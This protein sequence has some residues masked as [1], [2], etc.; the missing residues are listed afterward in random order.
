MAKKKTAAT[1]KKSSAAPRGAVSKKP[2]LL[3][4]GGAG[5]I[6]SHTVR[7]LVE[8]G[9][10]VVVL[11]DLA[12]G[13]RAAIV[14]REVAFVKGNVGDAKT[15]E[16]IFRKHAIEGVI[17]FAAW[18]SV[19]ESVREPAKYYANNTA[20][21]LVLLDAMKRHGAKRFIFSS[22]AATFGNPQYIPIDE[23]HPQDPINPYGMSKLMLERILGD[24]DPAWG[25]RSV[26]LRYF[27]ACGASE[28]GRIGE[29]HDPET[30]LIPLVLMAAAGRRP[31]I[32]VFGRDYPTPDGTCIR[33]YIHILDLAR[34]HVMALDYLRK[35]GAS[36]GLNLGTGKG[37]SVQEIIET[38]KRV[39]GLPIPLVE[40]DRRPGDPPELVANPALAEKTL[41][42]KAQHQDLDS[43]VGTAWAWMNGPSKGRFK[44]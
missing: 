11:D 39:T 7:M 17:H 29:D 27:N 30:H 3:V 19:P 25:L 32:T 2:A 44:K 10:R 34:A 24:F 36:I 15:V 14:D 33:D 26:K 41:G 43:I 13:H 20:A 5:Y 28:D 37:H 16:G 22:T 8:A 23:K 18:T 21:P 1:K 9:E 40:G 4:T 42:W 6:G 12:Y 31:N 35:G 38:C